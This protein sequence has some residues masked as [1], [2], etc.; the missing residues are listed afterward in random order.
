[1]FFRKPNVQVG[2]S[3]VEYLQKQHWNRPVGMQLQQTISAK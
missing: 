1:M 3:H 2:N